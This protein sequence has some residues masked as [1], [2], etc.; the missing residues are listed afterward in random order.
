MTNLLIYKDYFGSVEYS[1]ND[2]VFWGKIEFINDSVTFE[3]VNADDLEKEFRDT[4]DDYLE[5]CKKVGK[6]PEKSYTGELNVRE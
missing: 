1:A 5:T 6:K 3:A 4:V 2:R